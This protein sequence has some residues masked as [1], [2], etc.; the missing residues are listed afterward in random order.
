[1]PVAISIL[2]KYPL[3]QSAHEQHNLIKYCK[4]LRVDLIMSRKKTEQVEDR[5]HQ[6]ILPNYCPNIPPEPFLVR[7][8][9]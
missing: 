4:I 9:S 3:V 8:S 5:Y 1:M 2:L 7:W 6:L